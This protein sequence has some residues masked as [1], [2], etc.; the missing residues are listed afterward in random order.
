[1]TYSVTPC[2][3][4][5]L[6]QQSSELQQ[7]AVCCPGFLPTAVL[8]YISLLQL[9]LEGHTL[10][11]TSELFDNQVIEPQMTA[12]INIK[13]ATLFW[14]HVCELY[15]QME[16]F[17]ILSHAKQFLLRAISQTSPAALSSSQ[18]R[19]VTNKHI[20][21]TQCTP[22]LWV[23][24]SVEN[25]LS[26]LHPSFLS[27]LFAGGFPGPAGVPVC[28]S[29]PRGGSSSLC[30]P[31]PSQPQPRDGLPLNSWRLT[32]RQTVSSLL[33]SLSL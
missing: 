29:G 15:C 18:L 19:Q 9:F 8:C 7:R 1:M 31:W 33:Q 3:C 27:G 12:H 13:P 21:Y 10:K 14:P 20:L 5:L 28:R 30:A 17:Q 6:L 32:L 23:I 11:A 24:S 16:P 2:V 22:A 4:S 26:R 25:R